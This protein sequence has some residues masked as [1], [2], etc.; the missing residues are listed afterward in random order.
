[1]TPWLGT[2]LYPELFEDVDMEQVV[3]DFYKDWYQT[4]IDAETASEILEGK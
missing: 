1:M 2:I 3:M 4:E